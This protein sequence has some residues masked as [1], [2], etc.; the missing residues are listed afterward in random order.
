MSALAHDAV[1]WAAPDLAPAPISASHA[2]PSVEDLQAIEQ[3]AHADGYA[4]GHAEGLASGQ[5]EV[6][7]I[8]AQMEGILDAFTR[9]LSRLDAE[10]GDA[11]GD[12]A[13][14]IAGALL[15]RT[16]TADPSLLI[17]L[18]REALDI[19]G[20]DNRQIE[21]RL[22]PDDLG[23]LAPH[24]MTLEGVRMNADTTLARGDLRLHADSVRIDGSLSARLNAAL[25]KIVAGEGR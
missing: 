4:R 8:V 7:R 24:L 21:L 11:L 13:V 12:L 19:A 10:V 22:H 20:S 15:G 23:L 3:A 14:R 5:A 6:R 17:D 9:P 2:L 25:Q 1:R 18:V 16:Y